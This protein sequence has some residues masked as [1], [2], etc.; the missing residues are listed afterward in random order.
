LPVD[1]A[2]YATLVSQGVTGIAN[3]DLGSDPARA[4]PQVTHSAGLKVIPYR[5]TGLSAIL[6]GSGDLTTDA[7]RLVAQLN[8]WVDDD[9]LRQ[10]RAIFSNVEQ[11]TTTLAGQRDAIPALLARLQSAAANVERTA[12]GLEAAVAEDWPIIAGDL[13]ATSAN[14]LSVSNRMDR[15]LASNDANIDR[16]LG[17]G[18]PSLTSLVVDLGELADR[19]SRL[20][21]KLSED[22]SRLVYRARHDPVVAA[23]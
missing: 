22:P 19:I 13:K 6:A 12:Q 15:L 20:S 11:V 10:L 3:V 4:Q 1:A 21:A 18:L 14:L 2:T 5:A 9:N 16:M 8:A 23:P 7:R 17:E